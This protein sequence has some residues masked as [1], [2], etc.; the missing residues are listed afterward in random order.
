MFKILKSPR[1]VE[2]SICGIKILA[3]K[4]YRL[5]ANLG[6]GNYPHHFHLKC[7]REKYNKELNILLFGF[8]PSRREG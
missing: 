5:T 7:F 4:D 1:T 3:G 6:S 8:N 2:C